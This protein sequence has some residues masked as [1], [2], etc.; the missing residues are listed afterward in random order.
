[1]L[2]ILDQYW[3]IPAREGLASAQKKLRKRGLKFREENA[4]WRC[5]PHIGS[6]TETTTAGAARR[7]WHGR[8]DLA[9]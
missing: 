7:H 6:G 5:L 2:T 1:L 8:A 9:Q 4:K 3:S